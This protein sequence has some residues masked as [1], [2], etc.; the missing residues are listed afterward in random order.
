MKGMKKVF[1][2]VLV[3]IFAVGMLAACGNSGGDAPAPAGS[4]SSAAPAPSTM[5]VGLIC[6]HDEN[7]TYDLNF[8]NGFKEACEAEGVEYLIRTNIGET[9]DCYDTAVD[10]ADKGCTLI[11]ADSFGHE[12][13]MIQAA[14]EFTDVQFAHA[15]GTKAHT[16]NLPNYANAFASIYEGRFLA[17]VA[18]GMKLNEM[19]AAGK[20]TADQAK[21]G[22]VGAYTYAEVISGYTSFYLGAKSVCP[23]VTM[24]VTFTG[25]WYDP[26]AEQ[27]GAETLIKRGCVLISQHADSLGAPTACENA[28]VPNVSYNGST[29]A[30]GPNTFIV[31]SRI[32]WAPYYRYAIQCVR[33]GKAID[34]DWTGTLETDSVQLTEV[35]EAVAAEG[36]AAAIEDVKAKLAS[37]EVKV[38][39]T[40]TFTVEG[41]PVTTYMADVDSDP[42]YEGDTE[43][44][45]DG[46]FAESKFRSAP[47]FD[48]QIDGITLLDTAF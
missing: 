29:Q 36:T 30:A 24:D 41:A 42:A 47:Y 25:S 28:G 3:A 20:I 2:L 8:I 38:F 4:G 12:D 43:V 10:L 39:D 9:Q 32:N 40:T 23:T 14:K 7:S 16:E 27:E 46:A 34:K 33:E 15:T 6:L 5:K 37:G 48:L 19:I 11:C 44:V 22:Y 21:M 17:G 35:N 45:I 26:A 1:A 18:A 13:Y 31:S